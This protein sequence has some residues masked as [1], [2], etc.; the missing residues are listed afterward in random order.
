M[1]DRHRGGGDGTEATTSTYKQVK[2]RS[3]RATVYGG[4]VKRTSGKNGDTQT[5]P[6]YGLDHFHRS[7]RHS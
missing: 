4:N 5:T 3:V 6:A 7:L 2:R 1:K